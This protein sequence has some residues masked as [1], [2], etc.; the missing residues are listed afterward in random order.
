MI[1]GVGPLA[2]AKTA[3]WIRKN[4]AGVHIPDAVIKRLSSAEN[5]QQEGINLCIDMINQVKEIEGVHGVHIM[6]YRQER[7]VPEIVERSGILGDRTPWHPGLIESSNE[8][9]WL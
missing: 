4:V 3:E 2:S 5:Q 8:R 6:A 1:I 7:N 9:A